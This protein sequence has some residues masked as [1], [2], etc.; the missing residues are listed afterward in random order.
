MRAR[1]RS[2]DGLAPTSVQ[3]ELSRPSG[4]STGVS[5]QLKGSELGHDRVEA[6][7]ELVVSDVERWW[8][9][10]HG[11][12]ALYDVRLLVDDERNR[13]TVDAGRVGFRSLA[14]GPS[15]EH[16][17]LKDG[18]DLHVNDVRVFARGAVWTPVE[19]RRAGAE[20]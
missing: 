20:P 17:V 16:D 13:L 7:G 11:D 6:S 18:L 19:R 10:T 8:P 2:L 9:H 12:P 15:I 1:L 3:L 14:F 5:L 4:P